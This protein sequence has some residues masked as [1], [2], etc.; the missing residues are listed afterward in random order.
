[1]SL[2]GHAWK[3]AC[4]VCGYIVKKERL[5]CSG[6]IVK[7]ERLACSGDIVKKER[8][9]CSG[10]SQAMKHGCSNSEREV[11]TH[12]IAQDREIQKCAFCRQ[13]DVDAVL[14]L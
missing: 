2:N 13:S 11:E 6:D 7:K 14:G 10:L 4:S 8:L 1:M 3:P 12:V 9:A 5:A